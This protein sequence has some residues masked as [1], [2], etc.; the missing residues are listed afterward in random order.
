[1]KKNDPR[2]PYV[3]VAED[4]RIA[5]ESGQF[6]PGA[7][8]PSGRDMAKQYG[9]AL[10][11]LQRALNTLIAEGLIVSYQGRGVWVRSP[12]HENTAPPTEATTLAQR[13]GAM[14]SNFEALENRVR[15]LER[16]RGKCAEPP[17]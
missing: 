11:T 14:E 8:L 4:L 16:D 5:I 9:V 1:M 3:Q 10:M 17:S 6:Q 13:L 15:E 12:E 2:P 7:R